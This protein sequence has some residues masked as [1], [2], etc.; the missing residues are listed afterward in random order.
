[1]IPHVHP[2]H[3]SCIVLLQREPFACWSTCR[4]TGLSATSTCPSPVLRVI[5]ANSG[6]VWIRYWR[7]F[8]LLRCTGASGPSGTVLYPAGSLAAGVLSG[9]REGTCR[10]SLGPGAANLQTDMVKSYC[11]GFVA[12]RGLTWPA[13]NRLTASLGWQH[14]VPWHPGHV[15]LPVSFRGAHFRSRHDRYKA[16]EG[17]QAKASQSHQC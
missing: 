8:T 3:T 17:Y 10:G 2:L 14:L 12:F 16:R 4:S 9:L 11:N 5:G 1:M 7:T 13:T 15:A 6:R